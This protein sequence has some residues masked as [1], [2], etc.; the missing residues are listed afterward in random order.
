MATILQRSILPANRALYDDIHRKLNPEVKATYEQ[1]VEA[2]QKAVAYQQ[3]LTEYDNQRMKIID[4]MV[5]A[6]MIGMDFFRVETLTGSQ[7]PMYRTKNARSRIPITVVSNMGGSATT[8]W[9][10]GYGQVSFNLG[11][12]ESDI[13]EYDRWDLV[14]GFVEKSA[15]VNDDLAYSLEYKMDDMAWVALNACF[16]SFDATTWILDAK[17]KNPPTTNDIDISDSCKGKL[18]KDLF[19]GVLD[20]FDRMEKTVRAIY[21]PAS[22]R[23]DVLDWMSVATSDVN[24]NII[25]PTNVTDQIWRTAQLP[26]GGVIPPIIFTNMLEGETGNIYCYAVT[27]QP[28]GILYQ[29]PEG[30]WTETISNRRKYST[31]SF[32]TASFVIPAYFKPEI[33]RF[34]IGK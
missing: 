4:L 8:L 17:I 31:Q 20:H 22:R 12:M 28:C 23:H 27:S 16:G 33:A 29:K 26:E 21:V 32:I 5:R 1:K 19:K 13:V 30:H 3:G 15:E 6:K 7:M 10:D 34:Q 2:L 9:S 25:V 24:S 11:Q 18:T 14:Q